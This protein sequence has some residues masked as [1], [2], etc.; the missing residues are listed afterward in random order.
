MSGATQCLRNPPHRAELQSKQPFP[1]LLLLQ[2]Q[3]KTLEPPWYDQRNHTDPAPFFFFS[4]QRNANLPIRDPASTPKSDILLAGHLMPQRRRKTNVWLGTT[5]YIPYL[6]CAIFTY[7]LWSP[8]W[9][10]IAAGD[11]L[12]AWW[13]PGIIWPNIVLYQVQA[14]ETKDLISWM[15]SK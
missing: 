1:Y 10:F 7:W 14:L 6:Q 4:T 8:S 15:L 3:P 13:G 11:G 12:P 9:E 2:A 5:S